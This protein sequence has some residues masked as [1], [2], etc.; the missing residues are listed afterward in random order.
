MGAPQVSNFPQ[1]FVNGV[2]LKGQ[3]ILQAQ[4]GKV[5]WLSNGSS[6]EAGEVQGADTNRGTFFRPFATLA[7]ALTMCTPGN[8]DIIFVKPGHSE[9]IS[10]A[11]A[12]TV[13]MSDVS[14]VGLGTGLQRPLFTLGTAATATIN[15]SAA[16]VTFQN[17]QFVANFANITAL[18]THVQASVT[19]A[20]AGNLL[21][22]SAVGSGTLGIGNTL[23]GTGVSVGTHIIAQLTGTTGGVGTYTVDISQTVASGTITT[24]TTGFTLDNC[25]VRDTSAI[26]NFLNVVT[27]STVSN[28]S[29]GLTITNNL[30]NSLATSGAVTL[31]SLL[32]TT[33]RIL[34]QGNYY[35]SLTT[36]AG[37]VMPFATGKIATAFRLLGNRFNLQNAAGTATGYLIT[38]NGTTNTGFIDGNFDFALPTTPLPI[39][40]SSGFAYGL[41]YH[42]DAAD[43]AGYLVPVADT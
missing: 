14:V 30:V 29:D 9:T 42:T 5:F 40:L 28:A 12:L 35:Q 23:S 22:V 24:L 21:T 4:P 2:I 33:D 3:P 26:L 16:D 19:A 15:I 41:H 38:T 1:G 10:S 32:G 11:T 6:L 20:I 39:T 43:K 8:G 27:L 37:A 18:F 34:I 31:L 25:E 17:I 36:N 7:G 13:N